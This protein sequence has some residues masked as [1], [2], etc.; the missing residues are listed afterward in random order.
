ME[1]EDQQQLLRTI[2]GLEESVMLMPA[3]A[4]KCDL[5]AVA[6]QFYVAVQD[7]CFVWGHLKAGSSASGI[8][9]AASQLVVAKHVRSTV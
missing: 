8:Q 3:Y 1:E 4:G 9:A 5:L 7:F 6:G 2:P